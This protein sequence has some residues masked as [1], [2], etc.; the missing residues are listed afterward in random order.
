MQKQT[1][2]LKKRQMRHQLQQKSMY[3]RM[4]CTVKE[5]NK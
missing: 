2:K 5:K 1:F 3:L 4:K